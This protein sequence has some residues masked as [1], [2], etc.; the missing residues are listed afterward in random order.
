VGFP[1]GLCIGGN[2]PT[3]EGGR[4]GTGFVFGGVFVLTR[5]PPVDEETERPDALPA[6]AM[7]ELFSEDFFALH[8]RK[9]MMAAIPSFSSLVTKM[10]SRRR[11]NQRRRMRER[12]KCFPKIHLTLMDF[13]FLPIRCRTVRK[14]RLNQLRRCSRSLASM[15]WNRLT[16]PIEWSRWDFPLDSCRPRRPILRPMNRRNYRRIFPASR[17]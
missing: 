3:V 9:A 13:P 10:S 7:S 17:F 6:S 8:R 11:M 16:L 12:R 4:A 1:V 15:S 14:F 5:F 2:P